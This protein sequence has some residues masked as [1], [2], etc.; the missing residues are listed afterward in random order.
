MNEIL[1][2]KQ[3][4]ET[5]K[6][7]EDSFG[8]A[9]VEK[10]NEDKKK[11]FEK[12]MDV[13]EI[14]NEEEIGSSKQELNFDI[15]TKIAEFTG[16]LEGFELM[17]RD[18][19]LD[20][21][22][23]NALKKKNYYHLN[24]L[25]QDTQEY[26]INHKTRVD[27]RTNTLVIGEAGAGKSTL[28]NQHKRVM[29]NFEGYSG[30]IE[31]SGVSHPEQLVG[32][33][34]YR[35]RGEKKERVEKKGLLGYKG[36]MN[37]E[38]QD[39]LNEKNDIYAKSQR[40]KRI[41]MDV[42]GENEISK[43]LVDDSVEDS[44]TY[45][46]EVRI[47]D[48]A[49]PEKLTSRFFDTGSFRRYDSFRIDQ[50]ED[51]QLED[52]TAFK[53]ENE[54]YDRSWFEFLDNKYS[55][56]TETKFN[57][58]TLNI[59]SHYHKTMLYFLLNHK[60]MNA[61]RYGLLTRYSMRGM[62]CTN[63]LILAKSRHEE[64]ASVTTTLQACA[65]TILFILKTIETYNSLGNMGTAADVWGGLGEQDAQALEY[66]YKKKAISKESSEIS[67]KKFQTILANLYGCKISQS[68]S[69]HY[70]LKRDGF[71]DSAQSGKYD[72]RVWLK[73]IPK[74]IKLNS[75]NYDPLKFLEKYF[76]GDRAKNTLLT[77]LKSCFIDDKSF[78]KFKGDK[79]V[80]VL[81]CVLTPIYSNSKKYKYKYNKYIQRVGA[82]TVTPDTLKENTQKH[83]VLSVEKTIKGV[84]TPKNS[85]SPL[86]S[87][88]DDFYYARDE[89]FLVTKEC[90]SI[91]PSCTKNQVK[92]WLKDNPKKNYKEL[93]KALG[94]G[95]LKFKNEIL[96][97]IKNEA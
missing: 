94:T 28:K 96:K 2:K 86:T 53:F 59:I 12:Y 14:E 87:S 25:R 41:G 79:G 34:T 6:M 92:K 55:R 8:K 88:K 81:G 37:D 31:V 17:D 15:I 52:I 77:A 97:E 71:I 72:S 74:E 45:C 69:H 20:G 76:K 54:K 38:A 22:N 46:P 61:F 83:G 47:L 73:F 84:K 23:Y 56:Q 51:L 75:E 18:L 58:E 40:L 50:A 29:R 39:M 80:G 57:E 33:V 27:N 21:E 65:D 5:L 63:V 16:H 24:S 42:H 4:E 11:R 91:K 82:N 36:L 9:A 19:G 78:E 64:I 32:K 48:F 68:R 60:N 90:E 95:S 7:F 35:G 93:Y 3:N 49:H 89:Q 13:E 66:L 26:L 62:F 85:L 1:D 43:K 10:L 70:R 67:V 44:M 30:I